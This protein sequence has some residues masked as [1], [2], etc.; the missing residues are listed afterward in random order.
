MRG[1]RIICHGDGRGVRIGAKISGTPKPGV[2][3]EPVPASAETGG[4][5]SWRAKTGQS[6]TKGL[7]PI[8]LEDSNQGFGP[9]QAYVDATWGQL[10]FPLPGEY[11]NVR[12]V[13]A[14]TGTLQTSTSVG[15]QLMTAADSTG[16][17]VAAT[18]GAGSIPYV[19]MEAAKDVA[20]GD[21]LV[22][23]QFTGQ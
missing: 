8:L 3:M 20:A 5:I 12:V 14:G 18:P 6:G 4:L 23:C 1:N 11:M 21:E 10:Y 22:Y 16:R 9:N 15:E 13:V 19:C 7:N 17:F 2:A